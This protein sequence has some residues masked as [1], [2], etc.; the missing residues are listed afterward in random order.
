MPPV[1]L[2]CLDIWVEA[3]VVLCSNRLKDFSE[4]RFGQLQQFCTGFLP[5]FLGEGLVKSPFACTNPVPI[6]L[7]YRRF[8]LSTRLRL[9]LGKVCRRYIHA[10]SLE[11]N[12][13]ERLISRASK[14]AC[15]RHEQ[16]HNSAERAS[17]ARNSEPIARQCGNH[18]L[19][20][21]GRIIDWFIISQ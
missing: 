9:S 1:V 11:H 19:V 17:L 10:C 12:I 7:L 3:K 16:D 14:L 5:K 20:I 6:E 13:R 15:P 8:C 21:D 18:G 2:R 4:L